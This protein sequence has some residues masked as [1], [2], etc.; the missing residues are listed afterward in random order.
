[1]KKA[2]LVFVIINIAIIA[3]LGL[4]TFLLFVN[5]QSLR[6]EFN[7]ANQHIQEL[8]VGMDKLLQESERV[9]QE[10]EYTKGTVSKEKSEK[11]EL[12]KQLDEVNSIVAQKD[13]ELK[14]LQDKNAALQKDVDGLS[15][16]NGQL[17]ENLSSTETKLKEIDLT[18]LKNEGL[19]YIK[20]QNFV[21]AIEILEKYLDLQPSDAQGH[22][23]LGF[24]YDKSKIDKEKALFHYRLSLEF[25]PEI[26]EKSEIEQSIK[27]LESAS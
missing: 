26:A 1:M 17:S 27:R 23:N 19:G 14:D 4:A 3:G 16:K 20:S 6:L 11:E 2:K 5:N 18:G 22:Y 12:Q 7:K 24:A 9:Q 8:E 13:S 10:L 25:D 21:K 15:E